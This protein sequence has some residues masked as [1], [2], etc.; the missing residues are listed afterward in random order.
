MSSWPGRKPYSI[1]NDQP[2]FYVL[3]EYS[4]WPEIYDPPRPILFPTEQSARDFASRNL[5]ELI[6]KATV[7]SP[8]NDLVV[9]ATYTRRQ[10]MRSNETPYER[11]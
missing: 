5:S 9:S 10:Y 4:V 8:W 2:F 7:Y 3:L 11:N 6:P 1:V